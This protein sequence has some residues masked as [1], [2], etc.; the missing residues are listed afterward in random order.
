MPQICTVAKMVVVNLQTTKT[1]HT[2]TITTHGQLQWFNY[3]HKTELLYGHNDI[4][5]GSTEILFR[6]LL[7]YMI[8]RP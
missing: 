2:S 5:L 1:K 4:I 7:P 6:D 8:L 3:C